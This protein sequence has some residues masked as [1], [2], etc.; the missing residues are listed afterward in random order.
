MNLFLELCIIITSLKLTAFSIKLQIKLRMD[1]DVRY[2]VMLHIHTSDTQKC[3]LFLCYSKL[4]IS[5]KR[6]GMILL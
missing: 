6:L 4:F 5:T 3:Q 1:I 2:S